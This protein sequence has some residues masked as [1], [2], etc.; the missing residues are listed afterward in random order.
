MSL[1]HGFVSR[2]ASIAGI[3]LGIIGGEKNWGI[4]IV[5]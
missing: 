2:H 4:L 1:G 3:I 5:G